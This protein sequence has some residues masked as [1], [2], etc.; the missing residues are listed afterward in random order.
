MSS[1]PRDRRAAGAAATV[2]ALILAACAAAG[3]PG[4]QSTAAQASAAPIAT[5]TGSASSAIG[6]GS[7]DLGSTAPSATASSVGGSGG[8]SSSPPASPP[9]LLP[10]LPPP[11]A[12]HVFGCA[13]LL[14]GKQVSS[15]TRIPSVLFLVPASMAPKL[16]K[17]E[18][19]CKYVGQKPAPG[20]TYDILTTDL[21]VLTD[22]ARTAFD[23]QWNEHRDS[24]LVVTVA[25]V[26]DDAAWSAQQF[27]LFG[28][29]GATAFEVTLEPSPLTLFTPAEARATAIALARIVVAHL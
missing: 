25:G 7:P 11:G 26:G 16:P 10:P 20:R 21:Y 23:A 19:E 22:G 18:T 8:G 2:I 4:P 17:G 24:S 5:A 15:A 12:A 28:I 14:T 29:K 3:T 1:N 27:S 13:S 6:A 9:P